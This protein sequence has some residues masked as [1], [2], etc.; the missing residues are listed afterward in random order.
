MGVMVKKV[1]RYWLPPVIWGALIFS[2]SSTTVPQVSE[3]YWQDF[4]AHKTAHVI[5]YGIL[6]ILVYRALL[7]EKINKKQAVI[8][9]I[10]VAFLYGLTDELHQSFTPFRTSRLRDVIIDTIGATFSLWII[11]SIVLEPKA[12]I[13]AINTLKVK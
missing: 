7:Q 12:I 1:L 3:V 10:G 2:V 13:K 9:A 4:V 5:E 11:S 8:F 6:G